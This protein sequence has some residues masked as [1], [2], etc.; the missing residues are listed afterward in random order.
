MVTDR[1]REC[2]AIGCAIAVGLVVEWYQI[3]AGTYRFEA[4]VLRDGWPPPW[5][6]AMWGQFATAFRFSM[7]GI[8]R[9][10]WSAALFGAV[11]GPLAFLAG[12]RLGA[13]TLLPPTPAGLVRLA[14]AW[15][16][17]LA[18]LSLAARVSRD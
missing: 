12:E 6:I 5:L 8:M 1:K 9:R 10:W 14:I 3:S 7:Q 2:V 17:A 11:G 15:A 16:I 13:V 4:G 18:V